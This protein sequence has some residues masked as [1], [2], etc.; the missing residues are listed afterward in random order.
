[1]I[2]L[3]FTKPGMNIAITCYIIAG[4]RRA[5]LNPLSERSKK[6]G[7]SIKLLDELKRGVIDDDDDEEKGCS[8]SNDDAQSNDD[9]QR[10]IQ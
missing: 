2:L 5:L 6:G 8:G 1:M 3:N 10:I 7:Q 4:Q 9:R